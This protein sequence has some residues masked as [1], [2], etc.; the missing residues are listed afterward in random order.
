MPPP[1]LPDC[2]NARIARNKANVGSGQTD[3]A[4]V[5]GSH[6]WRHTNSNAKV[7][8]IQKQKKKY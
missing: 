2:V 8:S 4:L 5:S 7:L 1:T 3:I 6:Q